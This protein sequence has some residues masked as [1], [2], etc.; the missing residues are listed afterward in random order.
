[1][2]QRKTQYK[3]IYLTSLKNVVNL[4]LFTKNFVDLQETNPIIGFL[5]KMTELNNGLFQLKNTM[6]N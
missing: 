5:Q 1:M 4:F 6:K 2:I 3:R